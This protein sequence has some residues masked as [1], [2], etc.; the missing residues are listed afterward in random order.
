MH[1]HQDEHTLF[2]GVGPRKRYN[3]VL[4]AAP[5]MKLEVCVLMMV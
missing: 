1:P 2:G 5:A 3:A 4:S